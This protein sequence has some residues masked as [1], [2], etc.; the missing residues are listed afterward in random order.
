MESPEVSQ[1]KT[2][3]LLSGSYISFVN[4]SHRKDRL[5]RMVDTLAKRNIP[6]VR[7]PGLSVADV[8]N[9]IVPRHRLQVMLNRPPGAI[10]CHFAH[11]AVMEEARRQGKHAWVVAD[12][13]KICPDIHE[14]LAHME[15]FCNTHPWDILWLGGTFHVNPPHWH[16]GR[17]GR[18]LSQDAE[19]TDDPRMMRTYGAFCT[20]AY[21]VNKDSVGKV[22]EG[23]DKWLDRSMGIDWAMIQ[24][25]PKLQTF[26]YVPGCC[27][28]Y[29]N[30][31]D[32]GKGMTR[33]SGFKK[34]GP[35]WLANHKEDFDPTKFN[36][37][38]ATHP[39]KL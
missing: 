29:D 18:A 37:H 31:S 1:P 16:T 36:W 4:L 19:C 32:I 27:T 25:Q 8:A 11:V 9:K 22:L 39:H 12:D 35:Y 2:T 13:L 28:Q 30:M 7:T 26:A 17:K 15:T 34:L 3:Q 33:F 24:L 20:Y 21:I 10:G 5:D 23:L 38:E 6:A 14:R